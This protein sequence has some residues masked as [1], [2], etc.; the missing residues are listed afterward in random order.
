[1]ELLDVYDQKGNPTGKTVER[2]KQNQFLNNNEYVA[3]AQIYIENEKGEFL[4][5]ESAKNTD[6]E[7]VPVGGHLAHGET[8]VETILREAKE[9]LEYD[10]PKER[11]VYLEF[12]VS[13]GRVRHIF[14]LKDNI[15]IQSLTL[16]KKEV[17]N[18]TYMSVNT[19]KD[20]INKGLMR[21]SQKLLLERVLK[22][23]KENNF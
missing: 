6:E 23:K 2:G 14:Y 3:I 10:I 11:L 8:A 16:Q 17:K 12:I 5:E 19:I 22:Y 18:V 1:M 7:F 4:I 21:P 20:L 9:E 13:N 15:N